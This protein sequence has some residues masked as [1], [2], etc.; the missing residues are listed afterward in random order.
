[1]DTSPLSAPV[2]TLN[3]PWGARNLD[4]KVTQLTTSKPDPPLHT[5]PRDLETWRWELAIGRGFIWGCKTPVQPKL[6]G[7]V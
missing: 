6:A 4:Q 5:T 1:M 3:L 2:S 7:R